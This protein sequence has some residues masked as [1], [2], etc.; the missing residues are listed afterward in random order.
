MTPKRIAVLKDARTFI[1]KHYAT[2]IEVNDERGRFHMLNFALWMCL[3][4][5]F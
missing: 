3:C 5:P 4:V 1:V 2:N